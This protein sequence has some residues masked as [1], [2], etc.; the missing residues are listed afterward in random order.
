MSQTALRIG[1][2][3]M[4]ATTVR[5]NG[6]EVTPRTRLLQ[7]E[8]PSGGIVW[9]HPSAVRITRGENSRMIPVIDVTFIIVTALR[10]TTLTVLA[11]AALVTLNAKRRGD[12]KVG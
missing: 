1:W 10:V 2:Y 3:T 5:A 12:R 4:D 6:V 11:V 7:L 9:N 8:Y